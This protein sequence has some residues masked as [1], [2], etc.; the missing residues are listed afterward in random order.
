MNYRQLQAELNK[1]I[2]TST[3]FFINKDAY[4][5][6]SYIRL[7]KDKIITGELSSMNYTVLDEKKLTTEMLEQALQALPIMA[8]RRLLLIKGEASA[9][10]IKNTAL[11]EQIC[12]FIASPNPNLVLIM[13][14]PELK[15]KSILYKSF[16]ENGKIVE[17]P[18]LTNAELEQ[19]IINA[20][21]KR[22]QAINKQAVSYI[23]QAVDYNVWNSSI[24]LEYVVNEIEKLSI[25]CKNKKNITLEDAKKTVSINATSNIYRYADSLLAGNL[26][27]AMSNMKILV[28]NKVPIQF[29]MSTLNNV[30]RR[31]AVWREARE[32]GISDSEIAKKFSQKAYE[33]K[34]ISQYTVKAMLST[35]K[36][37][38]ENSLIALKI[39][40]R[41]DIN[42]K[43]SASTPEI[44]YIILTKEICALATNR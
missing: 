16:S 6:T 36:I 22:K 40:S 3:Y 31:N 26:K 44:S 32:S 9:S 29:T 33:K 41:E 15:N 38:A 13:Q 4:I 24:D 21:T 35:S 30:F 7:I 14:D 17:F 8:D 23:M 37:S 12:K 43:N 42:I 1:N 28:D 2:I 25:F 18:K 5:A 34:A 27:E 20:F 10:I 19:Y 11:S 39:I